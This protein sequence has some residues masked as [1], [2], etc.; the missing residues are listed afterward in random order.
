MTPSATR[1]RLAHRAR[2]VA[3]VLVAILAGLTFVRFLVGQASGAGNDHWLGGT[4][5]WNDGTKWSTGSPPAAGDDVFIDAAGT[6]TVTFN[7]VISVHS[8]ILGNTTS[9][10]Q[11]LAV[12]GTGSD[13]HLA[14]TSASSVKTHG[15]VVLTS[16]GV[17]YAWWDQQGGTLT[18]NGSLTVQAGGT[19]LRYLYG[20]VVNNG[21][22]TVSTGLTSNGSMAFTNNQASATVSLSGTWEIDNGSF[23]N[24][25]GS[26]SSSGAAELFVNAG[27]YTQGGGTTSGNPVRVVSGSAV[28]SGSGAPASVTVEGVGNLSGTIAAGQTVTVSGTGSDTHL[29]AAAGVVDHGAVVLTSTGVGYAWWDQQGGTLTNN[30]SLTVQAG[31][32][33]LRYL[34]GTVVNNGSV[35]VSTGLTSNGSMAFTNNQASA[36]VSLSGTWEIDNGSFVNQ[37]GSVASSGAAELFV[38]AGTYTQGGGTTSGNPVRVVSGSAVFSGSGAPASVTVEGVGNLSGTIAAGQTVTVSGT[39]SDTHLVAAAGVVDHGAVVLTSTGVG[40]A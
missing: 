19:G 18:N 31:G 39:G 37:A 36:T 13:T 23:V 16:T 35:T 33:G 15:A 11:T 38:N 4:G 29:V 22:V 24:Q 6:Y 40:Y 21:S 8:V 1:P 25:A 34:Y 12:Q 7:G 10:T 14:V 28:F 9:G 5:N 3:L 26:V 32:T 30:G 17:G 2:Q 27:T 20:T